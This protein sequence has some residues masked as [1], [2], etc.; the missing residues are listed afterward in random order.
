[1]FFCLRKIAVSGLHLGM[2]F[3][4][5]VWFGLFFF[6]R[7]HPSQ[8]SGGLSVNYQHRQHVGLNCNVA[9]TTIS[10]F[11]TALPL[12]PLHVATKYETV[13][14]SS[15]DEIHQGLFTPHLTH[16]WITVTQL[17]TESFILNRSARPIDSESDSTFCGRWASAKSHPRPRQLT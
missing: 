11:G 2:V 13:V 9:K 7:C 12:S 16:V 8:R 5:A 17:F 14:W 10:R 1:M 4:F 15:D 3:W 6:D